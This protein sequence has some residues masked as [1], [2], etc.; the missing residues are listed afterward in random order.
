[1]Q[2]HRAT[3]G[4]GFHHEFQTL[5]G[6]GFVVF[7]VNKR[8]ALGYGQD[9]AVA[10]IRR[11]GGK[12]VD[13]VMMAVDW[14]CGLPYVDGARVGVTGGSSGGWLTNWL[15]THS[16][17]FRAACT[18]RSMTDMLSD[19]G[20]S[21]IGYDFTEWEISGLPWDNFD[22]YRRVSPITYAQ[23]VTTPLLIIHSEEDHRTPVTQADELYAALK[24]FSKQVEYVRFKGEGH[25][26]SRSGTPS[27]RIERLYRIIDW[28]DHHL[29]QRPRRL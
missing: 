9:Y 4:T 5:A 12:D 27:N 1:M 25:N 2:V 20:T 23:R 18:Q 16:D 7:Y 8:G 14:L 29:R 10:N 21:D 13:D 17:R 6:A 26:L 28:F 22:E 3:F 19:F 11:Y 15:V 24:R